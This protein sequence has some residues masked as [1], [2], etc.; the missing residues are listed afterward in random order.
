M[1]LARKGLRQSKNRPGKMSDNAHMESFFHSLKTKS[2]HGVSL[3]S[4]QQLR[5]LMRSHIGF[6]NQ[7][8]R[9]SSLNYMS[10]A[11]YEWLH[12]GATCIN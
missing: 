5:A 10:P 6:Y 3:D 11:A 1:Q 8:P 12:G 4:D 7:Q 9:H 2:L